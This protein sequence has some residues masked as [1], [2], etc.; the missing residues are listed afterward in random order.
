MAVLNK[1]AFKLPRVE[2]DKFILLIRLGLEYNREQGAYSIGS[3]NNIEKLVDAI[4]GILNED[5]KFLQS[6]II[7]GRDFPCQD[8]KYYEMCTTKDLPFHCV[9]PQCLRGGKRVQK[10]PKIRGQGTLD[11]FG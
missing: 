11:L 1:K 10:P 9:C 5:V 4:S 3:C 7:C 8:C 6:C 2:K